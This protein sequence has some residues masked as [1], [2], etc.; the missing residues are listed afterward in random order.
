MSHRVYRK[1]QTET[2]SKGSISSDG[3]DAFHIVIGENGWTG[4]DR[5]NAPENG[6][7]QLTTARKLAGLGPWA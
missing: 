1:N 7:W 3:I 6:H 4:I 2:E 5:R